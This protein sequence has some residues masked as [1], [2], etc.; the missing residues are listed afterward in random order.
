MRM[1][2][3]LYVNNLKHCILIVITKHIMLKLQKNLVCI[4]LNNIDNINPT[5]HCY[6]SSGL[7]FI[8]LKF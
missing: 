2:L 4:S 3:L 7:T 5:H 1:N 6:I 8:P